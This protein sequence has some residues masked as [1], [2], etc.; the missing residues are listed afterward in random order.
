MVTNGPD[1]LRQQD[2][3]GAEV[4]N[5]RSGNQRSS[6]ENVIWRR[7]LYGRLLSTNPLLSSVGSAKRRKNSAVDWWRHSLISK[8]DIG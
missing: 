7:R 3:E 2:G 5:F 8:G 6:G 4:A 1:R